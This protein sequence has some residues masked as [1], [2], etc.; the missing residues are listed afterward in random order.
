MTLRWERFAGS[1]DVFAIRL[2][3]LSDPDGGSGATAEETASWGAL[4][5]WV[6]GQNLCAHVDQGE[7]LQNAHWYMLPLL[8]WVA[9]AWNSL[10][11]EERL[12]NRN[13]ADDAVCALARTRVAPEL[14]GETDTV[15]WEEQWYDWWRRHALRSARSGGLLPN[16]VVRRLRDYVEVSWA[17]EPLAGAPDGFQFSATSGRAL[18]RP[19]DVVGPLYDI[20]TS[21]AAYLSGL[22]PTSDR[23]TVL[24]RALEGLTLPAQREVRVRL[25][26]GFQDVG[27]QN[28]EFRGREPRQATSGWVDIVTALTAAGSEEAV[29]AALETDGTDLVVTGSCSAS[30]LF[31]ALA[32]VVSERDVRTLAEVLLAR[33]AAEQA[34]SA[35]LEAL[36]AQ[37]PLRTSYM[38]W[39]QGYELAELLHEDLALSG[40]WV[41][42]EGLVSTLGITTM[43]RHLDDPAVRACSFVGPRHR[44]TIV[45]NDGSRFA[46]PQATRFTLAHELCHILFDRA[47]G[48][49]LAIASGPWAPRG[50]EQRAN[51][52]AAMFLMPPNLV[53]E[54]VADLPEPLTDPHGVRL[55][56]RRLRVSARAAAEHLYNLTLMDETTRD[57]ILRVLAATPDQPS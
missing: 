46:T 12:P 48:R 45:L 34:E 13:A 51:A 28:W 39:E 49:R 10:L 29:A 3:F 26:A 1:T 9:S 16:V 25:L 50:I 41:D 31:G 18:L 27:S 52:F 47:S 36:T 35:T 32:P 56:A 44:P 55:V 38:P 17:E 42:I 57:E 19:E 14:A 2:G 33:Y 7:I 54:A 40:D 22:V 11:H 30:L 43:R 6:E 4:Q 24:I 23:L 20:A 5:I 8:E 21:A 37:E 15:S 53:A